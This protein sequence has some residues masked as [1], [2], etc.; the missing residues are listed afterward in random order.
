VF[1]WELSLNASYSYAK[2]FAAQP[3]S[4]QFNISVAGS[5]QL[6]RTWSVAG[7]FAYDVI[8]RALNGI[9]IRITKQLHCWSLSFVWYPVGINSGFYLVLNPIASV[10]RDLK[11]EKR[12]T[13]VF[14]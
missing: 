10:L 2:P 8:S 12:S 7:G 13:P 4:E 5:L 11:I 9:N 6:T 14:Q 3:A 1:P